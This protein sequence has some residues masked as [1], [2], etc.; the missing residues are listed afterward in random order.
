M[1]SIPSQGDMP[2]LEANQVCALALELNPRS[3]S[4]QV[5]ALTTE[6]HWPGLNL[7]FYTFHSFTQEKNKN[8]EYYFSFTSTHTHTHTHT[9]ALQYVSH[10]ASSSGKQVQISLE[11]PW[12]VVRASACGPERPGF[13]SR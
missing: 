3:S 5:D 1:D 12:P 2:G 6:P 13:G 10:I 8:R 11:L 7:L 9:M 4:A